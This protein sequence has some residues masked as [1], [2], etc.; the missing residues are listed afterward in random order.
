MG[1]SILQTL[2]GFFTQTESEL[3]AHLQIDRMYSSY[4]NKALKK[5]GENGQRR[6]PLEKLVALGMRHAGPLASWGSHI[7]CKEATFLPLKNFSRWNLITPSTSHIRTLLKVQTVHHLW[8]WSDYCAINICEIIHISQYVFFSISV[9]LN[10]CDSQLV[11][12]SICAI[13]NQCFSQLVFFSICAI[14]N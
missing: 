12:F 13:L 10:L 8:R 14:L 4:W 5:G 2:L 6:L 11:F 7:L 3:A 1:K 9:F